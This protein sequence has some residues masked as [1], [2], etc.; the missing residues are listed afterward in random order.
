MSDKRNTKA[1][2]E[3]IEQLKTRV[4]YLESLIDEKD[5]LTAFSTDESRFSQLL[6]TLPITVFIYQNRRVVYLN[7]TGR[8]LGG[9]NL[10]DIIRKDFWSLIH[11]E[12]IDALKHAFRTFNQVENYQARVEIKAYDKAGALR[13]LDVMFVSI[14]YNDKPA[15]LG[16]V[17][18]VT[19]RLRAQE[20]HLALDIEKERVKVLTDFVRDVSHDFRTPLSTINTSI[21]LLGRI[22][23]PIKRQ[24]QLNTL[25]DQ[26][27]HLDKLVDA[28]LTMSRLDSGIVSVF[29]QFDLNLVILESI[30]SVTTQ[31]H[32]KDHPFRTEL[33]D[34]L[35]QIWG[36]IHEIHRALREL[37]LNAVQYTS[38]RGEI[39]V[40]SYRE[41]DMIIIVVQDSGYGISPEDMPHI[42]D[43]FFRADQAR[44]IGGVGSGLSIVRKVIEH[45]HG[46][47][48]VQSIHHHGTTFIIHLPIYQAN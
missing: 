6:E 9:H 21:Y 24:Q 42:F 5:V 4:A 18:D 14:R 25:R 13:F 17:V 47:I 36:D 39:V 8:V 11:P 29:N 38:P 15:L 20:Q 30:Q 48:D 28:L 10:P 34:D 44:T 37:M 26:V 46:Q 27:R 32:E 41:G 23:D 33:Q 31:A 35:P 22:D 43:R 16:T 45:H 3:E 19:E 1:L 40:R 2:L 7:P 12:S